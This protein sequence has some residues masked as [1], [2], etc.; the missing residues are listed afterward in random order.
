MKHYEVLLLL[1]L[2]LISSCTLFVG[3][4]GEDGLPGA[5]PFFAIMDLVTKVLNNEF[6]FLP[7]KC[8]SF[9]K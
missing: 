6:R 5:S 9:C 4:D 2:F 8:T 3:D 1:F 7:I